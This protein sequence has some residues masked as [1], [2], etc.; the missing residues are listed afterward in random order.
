M[1]S[2]VERPPS[3]ALSTNSDDAGLLSV[4]AHANWHGNGSALG[5]ELAAG[6]LVATTPGAAVFG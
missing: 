2:S 1:A 6:A 4:H 5:F 3:A